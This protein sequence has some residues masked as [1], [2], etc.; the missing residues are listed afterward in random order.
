MKLSQIVAAVATPPEHIQ[1]RDK[2][3]LPLF[4]KALKNVP[5]K[6]LTKYI[7]PR[8]KVVQ[9]GGT[10]GD[11]LG[12]VEDG[13]ISLG[14]SQPTLL[15]HEVMHLLDL[16]QFGDLA[17]MKQLRAT[18]RDAEWG[19]IGPRERVAVFME[20]YFSD[21]GSRARTA[22]ESTFPDLLPLFAAAI[23]KA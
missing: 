18:L 5:S 12:K 7:Y 14:G 19:A 2:A 11:E 4:K 17:E 6:L 3:L 1:F 9:F 20:W 22:L 8:L 16:S 21:K 10:Q 13:V 15:L 23:K